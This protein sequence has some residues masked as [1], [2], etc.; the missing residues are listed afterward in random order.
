MRGLE[1]KQWI[2]EREGVCRQN[3]QCMELPSRINEWSG[4][5]SEKALFEKALLEKGLLQ[6]GLSEKR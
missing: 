2:E 3:C 5:F 1:E 6:K 4:G